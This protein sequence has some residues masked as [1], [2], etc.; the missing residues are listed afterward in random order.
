MNAAS[1]NVCINGTFG[2]VPQVSV[3]AVD[4]RGAVQT[5]VQALNLTAWTVDVPTLNENVTSAAQL[6]FAVPL[7]RVPCGS[8]KS[9]SRRN[10][11]ASVD[12]YGA[13]IDQADGS[14]DA[15]LNVVAWEWSIIS[16]SVPQLQ[17]SCRV[18]PRSL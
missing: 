3:A 13:V 12:S 8:R 11:L 1:Q 16:S 5:D 17:V 15:V 7:T 18:G 2:E 9:A 6:C 10:V 4:A 14:T